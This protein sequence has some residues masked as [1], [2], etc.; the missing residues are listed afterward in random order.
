MTHKQTSPSILRDLSAVAGLYRSVFW[1][2]G[3]QIR[4]GSD[5]QQHLYDQSIR[6]PTPEDTRQ[7]ELA[8]TRHN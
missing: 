3:Q 1:M 4:H 2:L 7:R 6:I 8:A 5:W